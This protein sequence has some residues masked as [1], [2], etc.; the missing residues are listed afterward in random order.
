MLGKATVPRLTAMDEYFVH[1]IPELLPNV[2]THHEQWRESLFFIVHPPDGLGDV[3]ILTLAHFPKREHMDSLQLGRVG[4]APTI[5]QH[6]RPYDGDPH[7][8]AVGPVRIDIP[9]QHRRLADFLTRRGFE[10]V[11]QPPV[12][13]RNGNAL[14]PRGQLFAVASQ[15]FG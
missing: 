11:R 15:A 7:T 9:S 1:Q 5:G 3:L 13:M 12:M 8:M 6:V 14:P 10:T 4:G 2:Q